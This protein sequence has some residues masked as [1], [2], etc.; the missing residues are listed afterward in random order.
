MPPLDC[1]VARVPENVTRSCD[2][3]VNASYFWIMA[4]FNVIIMYDFTVGNFDNIDSKTW[5]IQNRCN[6]FEKTQIEINHFV[7]DTT[8]PLWEF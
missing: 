8:F 5:T 4:L 3:H 1:H 6:K 2:V 7:H